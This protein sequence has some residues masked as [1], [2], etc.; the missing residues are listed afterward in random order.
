MN[1]IKLH[2]KYFKIF[3]PYEKIEE[4]II[5]V[6]GRLNRDYINKNN[7]LFLS[8]LNGSFM[9]AAHLMKYL[10]FDNEI[11]FIRLSSYSGTSST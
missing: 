8:V 6:A 3:I 2:D 5:K 7:P 4:S 1:R 9:F 11:S 10:S